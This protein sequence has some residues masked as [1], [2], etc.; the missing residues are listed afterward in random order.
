MARRMMGLVPKKAQQEWMRWSL[1]GELAIVPC[2][3]V[4]S[5]VVPL[6]EGMLLVL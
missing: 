5:G 4:D 6:K 1:F 3:M 2:V